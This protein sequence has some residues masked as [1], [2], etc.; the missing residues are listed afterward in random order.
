MGATRCTKQKV[1]IFVGGGGST[2]ISIYDN[3]IKESI[4]DY[5]LWIRDI[6]PIQILT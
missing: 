5:S 1:C 3:G 4:R 6:N 2:E